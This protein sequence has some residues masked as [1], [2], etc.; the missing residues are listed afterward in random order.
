[1]RLTSKV[2][3]ATEIFQKKA[4]LCPT[5]KSPSSPQ[6][7]PFCTKRCREVDLGHWLTGSYY[8]AGAE[9]AVERPVANDDFQQLLG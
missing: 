3:D 7:A 1:M 5:C 8:I 9:K 2:Y 4:S 6:F